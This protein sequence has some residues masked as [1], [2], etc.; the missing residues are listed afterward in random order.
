MSFK[1]EGQNQVK[2]YSSISS[3]DVE[4]SQLEHNRTL[5]IQNMDKGNDSTRGSS[6][7]MSLLE[8]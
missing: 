2:G 6:L 3:V 7:E 1:L 5:N 8:Q 4:Q